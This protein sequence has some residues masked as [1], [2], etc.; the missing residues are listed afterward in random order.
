[1]TEE[2]RDI[3]DRTL[4]HIPP[5]VPVVRVEVPH[6]GAIADLA[7][8]ITVFHVTELAGTAR[9]IDPGRP[10][11]PL[12]GS[13]IYNLRAFANKPQT[14]STKSQEGRELP[15]L[16]NS[17][18]RHMTDSVAVAIRRKASASIDTLATRGDLYNWQ[19]AHE[20]FNTCLRSASFSAIVFDY[21]GTLCDERNRYSGPSKEVTD[22]LVQLI[23]N[24]IFIGIATGRGKSV[25]EA[26]RN[27]LASVPDLWSRVL[28]GYYNGAEIGL[29][30]DDACPEQ[31][32]N[33][34][35][36][37]LPVT[38]AL[39]LDATLK[40][41]AK[42]EVRRWQLTIDLK[43]GI[44]GDEVWNLVQQIVATVAVPGVTV[45]RSSHSIDV[46]AP[47]V[48]K[49][50]VVRRLEHMLHSSRGG[51]V[52]CIGDRGRWPG[53]DFTLLKEPYSLS[54]DE[55]SGDMETCWNLA[56]AGQRGV[57]ATTFYLGMLKLEGD[58]ARLKL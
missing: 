46:L 41:F 36:E 37:L 22:H 18:L 43:P 47:Q 45:L 6:S 38:A 39:E 23:R 25:R 30:T 53:N 9:G 40:R 13:K 26:L 1:M 42:H 33:T 11:V 28:V 29:L 12:F 3:A 34:C 4:R 48:N 50:S 10:G 16:H 5:S 56:P 35:A 17:P 57:Q 8:L 24:N 55:V 19:Q 20:R 31:T 58:R 32:N 52:L 27:A 44:S 49:R 15:L 7:A 14:A 51:D 2:D 21:D 54:V